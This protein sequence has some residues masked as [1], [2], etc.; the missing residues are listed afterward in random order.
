MVENQAGHSL[1]G[2]P[3]RRAFQAAAEERVQCPAA[4]LECAAHGTSTC[5]EVRLSRRENRQ[6]RYNGRF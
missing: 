2:S 1:A 4:L 6:R 5:D 3:A